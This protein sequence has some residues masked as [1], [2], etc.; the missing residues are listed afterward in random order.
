MAEIGDE[1]YYRK[2]KDEWRGL[3]KVIG[4]DGKMVLVKQGGTLT[5][6][7]RV[8][9]TRLKGRKEAEESDEEEV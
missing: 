3:G 6:V 2:E 9:I 8:H 1:V 5:E 4:R 7:T